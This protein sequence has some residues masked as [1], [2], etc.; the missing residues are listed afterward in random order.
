MKM[1]KKTLLVV[2]TLALGLAVTGCNKSSGV[3]RK[4]NTRK[5]ASVTAFDSLSKKFSATIKSLNYTDSSYIRYTDTNDETVFYDYNLGVELYRTKE[6]VLSIYSRLE[7]TALEITYDD[8]KKTKELVT[9]SGKTL[10]ERGEYISINANTISGTAVYTRKE[11]VY[12]EVNAVINVHTTGEYSRSFYKI[13]FKGIK[14]SNKTIIKDKT[15]DG[16]EYTSITQEEARKYNSGS[17]G[18]VDENY[19]R[20]IT[21][22]NKIIFYDNGSN[23]VYLE[24]TKTDS[25]TSRIFVHIHTGKGIVQFARPTTSLDYDVLYGGNKYILETYQIDVFNGTYKKLNDFK[26]YLS[27]STSQTSGDETLIYNAGYILDGRIMYNRN[28]A[29]N[30]DYKLTRDSATQGYGMSYIDLGNG[31]YYT[32]YNGL[33]YLVNKSGTIKKVFE[34]SVTFLDDAKVMVVKQSGTYKL[35]FM[36]YKG[37]YIN[38]STIKLSNGTSTKVSESA[39]FYIAANG[40]YHI[41]S[42]ENGKMLKDEVVEYGVGSYSSDFDDSDDL[43]ENLYYNSSVYDYYY[44]GTLIDNNGDSY[45]E[46]YTLTVYNHDDVEIGK[47]ENLTQSYFYSGYD[48]EGNTSHYFIGYEYSDSVDTYNFVIYELNQKKAK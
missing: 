21:S 18:L 38:E 43:S 28:L 24:M 5:N 47:M 37:N 4:N 7:N 14:S 13:T 39:L 8:E 31:Y 9:T 1:V 40:E 41:A 46:S 22:G 33:N 34:G 10:V 27:Q 32:N 15:K 36:D 48:A 42:F 44:K 2:S 25:A 6:K 19:I 29:F 35:D 20:Y 16:Y 30:K 17:E 12:E 23:K 11:K 26:Y 45:K 3:V